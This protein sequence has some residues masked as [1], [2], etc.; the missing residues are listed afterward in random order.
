M[1]EVARSQCTI[2]VQASDRVGEASKDFGLDGDVVRSLEE[3]VGDKLS[4]LRLLGRGIADETVCPCRVQCERAQHAK[5][6]DR[7]IHCIL[8]QR[9]SKLTSD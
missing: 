3:L 4:V 6:S 9:L 5:D 2:R 7:P 1:L 8:Q